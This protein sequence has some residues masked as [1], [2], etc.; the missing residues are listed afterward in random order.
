MTGASTTPGFFVVMESPYLFAHAGPQ[1]QS[2]QVVRI[3]G[4]N[5]TTTP[6]LFF[7]FFA[8]L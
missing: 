4:I 2:S 1:L 8:V 5:H 3:T 7:F 6:G